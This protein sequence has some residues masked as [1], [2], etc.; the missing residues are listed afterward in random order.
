MCMHYIKLLFAAVLSLLFVQCG[1]KSEEKTSPVKTIDYT[2]QN[3]DNVVC[4]ST[5]DVYGQRIGQGQGVYIAPDVV[6]TQ[7]DFVKGAFSVKANRID[8][9]QIINVFGYV[10]YDID[11]DLVALR[12][13][14][15]IKNVAKTDTTGK[16]GDFVVMEMKNKKLVA[17]SYDGGQKVVTG[18]PVFTQKG[19]VA[20]IC[21]DDGTII[22]ASEFKALKL[23]ESHES[24]YDLRLKTNKVYPSHE[25]VK[26]CRIVTSMG[27]ICI[28]LFDKT[29]EYRDNFIRLVS[30]HFYDS[31]LVHRVL[32]NYLIQTG[33]ADS[34]HAK[35]DDV[36]GWQGP[37]YKL[38]MR[39]VDGLYHKRGVVAASKL[40]S[41]NNA[42]NRSDGSQ[43][44]IVA[45]R[46]FTDVDLNEIERDYGKH[47][48]AEQR[49]TYKTIGGAPYLDGDY[50]IFGEV[51]SGM[52]V[53]DKIAGVRLNGDRPVNDIRVWRIELIRK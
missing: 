8:S 3:V 6:L 21:K 44:Y 29:P 13:G 45:G 20:G 51:T 52:D 17:R 50:T 43:F 11:R 27:N 35:S 32:A 10:A 40:P 46:K 26:G 1:S 4:L 31:L 24:I 30:D 15:R 25:T 23:T 7:M 41:D 37:G 22:P 9:K 48:T 33:A 19:R 28:R 47:F 12:I 39:L 14:K 18:M 16:S 34:K 38:P 49:E 53:V 2:A 42:S 36:V 5:Y